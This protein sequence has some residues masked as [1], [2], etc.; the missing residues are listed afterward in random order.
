MTQYVINIGA[1]PNDGTGDPLR[2][3]FNEV[4][5]NFDQV[6]AAGPVLSNIQIANNTI[7]T[8][9]TNGNLILA[10]NGIGVVQANV[11]VV[12][13][14]ANLRNL[15]AAD[16][17][18]NTLY[19]QYA[20]V[21][22]ALSVANLTATGNVTIGGNLSVTGNIIYIG[23]LITDAKTIQLS[24][25]AGTANAAN[26]SGITVG[27]N[28]DIATFLFDSATNT[29]NTN[30]GLQV[31]GAVTGTSIAVS[32]A[33]IYGNTTGINALFTGTTTTP[34]IVV[35]NI[36]SDDSTFVTIQDGLDVQGDITAETVNTAGNITGAYFIGN[37]SQLTGLN[38]TTSNI[39][40]GTSNVDIPVANGN[41]I[42]NA[43]GTYTWTFDDTGNLTI[44]NDIVSN[45]TIDIDNRASGNSADIRLY[46]ADDITLQARDRTLGSTSEGGDI[47]ILAG[48]SAEDSDSSG[49]D[50]Q[51]FAGDGGA[52]N[53]DFGGSGGFI[54]IQSGRGGAAAPPG[55]SGASAQSG[56][57][58]TLNA[59]DAG[60]N[61]G[62]IDRGADG[63]DVYIESGFSTGNTNSG[64]D[65][66]LTTGTGGQNGTSGNVRINIPGYG[67]TTGGTWRFN[68]NGST[69]YPT[70]T[71]TRGDRTG[72]LTGQTLLFGDSTQEAIISTPDGTN[73]INASQRFVINPGQGAPGT[74]GE[75]GDIYL[76]AGRGGDAGGS[77]G[78]IKIR[79][80]LGPVNGDGGYVTMEGGE[81]D[82]DGVGGYI[83]IIGGVSGN[84]AGGSLYMYGGQGRTGG[85]A[86][87]TGGF[88]SEGPG[89]DVSIIGGGSANG[90]AEY[91]N[92]IVATGSKNW[93]FDNT[94]NLVLPQGGIVYE[95]LIPGGA[96]TGN[97]IALKPSGG[98]DADQQ[99]LIYPTADPTADANHL[100]LTTGDLYNTELFLGNDNLYV[101]LA[102]TGNIVINSNDGVGNTAQWTFGTNES[103]TLPGGSRLRPLGANL[104]I[105]A[106][107][108]S[109]V[110]LI[111]SDESSYMG[112]GGA[113]GYVVTAGGTWD[114]N[115]N[116]NLTAPGNISAVGNI[117]GGNIVTSGSGGDITMS[118]GDIT[119]AG[120]ISAGNLIATG[121]MILTGSLVGSGASPAPSLSGFNSLSAISVSASGNI[122]ATGNVS[123]AGNIMVGSNLIVTAGSAITTPT[124]LANL[125]AVAG[126]RAF[127]NNANLVAAGNFGN[128]V[129]S[130]GSNVVPVWSDGSN[131]YIG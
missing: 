129:G 5:L 44:P 67:L 76:Y 122:T 104:D 61:N 3:A 66:V 32:S 37:G 96:L 124:A 52:A 35:N 22:G 21:S 117:T 57:S 73:D 110:N 48:D 111:T 70:L 126:G 17:R 105:F 84:A 120:N 125:T 121:N 77:G 128:Q 13:N 90:Q 80:G 20:N 103:L 11:N 55:G 53:V 115:T 101:K 28:D 4:N 16:Q 91:G 42:I 102:N 36:S 108:G 92:I 97:T 118:G 24:N 18:W 30:I 65:I 119:G 85:D 56:G 87:I 51:I 34:N 69:I 14:T 68:P 31:N 72:T 82:I 93:N 81:A 123:A 116:G 74:T 46:S 106:G 60:D 19:T 94:G 39:S 114:F 100:H 112:V 27:A 40:N 86:N 43:A 6:F 64:G 7:L 9:N 1:L 89:G 8:T 99:L 49:G 88:G 59:G 130:G 78:D 113:G 95:T 75:G 107:T 33:T 50:V 41:V 58:L 26:G 2:T 62:N 63:G 54:T 98:T 38:A 12:P 10:P 131:W 15:G 47:N 45:T 25:T 29:W 79:G 23:N 109:Y 83:E 71:I 127:V